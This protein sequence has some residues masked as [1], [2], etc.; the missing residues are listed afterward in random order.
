MITAAQW[1]CDHVITMANKGRCFLPMLCLV[2][3]QLSVSICFLCVSPAVKCLFR[4]R[5]YSVTVIMASKHSG[6]E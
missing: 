5:H 1:L 2:F 3:Q 4:L 6:C